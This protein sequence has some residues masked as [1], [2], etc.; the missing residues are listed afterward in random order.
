MNVKPTLNLMRW[1]NGKNIVVSL[2][3]KSGRFAC[4]PPRKPPLPPMRFVT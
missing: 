3:E 2:I 4:L 1:W